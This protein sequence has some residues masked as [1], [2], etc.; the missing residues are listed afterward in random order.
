M[1]VF[2]W[3]LS[4]LDLVLLGVA[5]RYLYKGYQNGLPKELFACA[6]AGGVL[7]VCLTY[8]LNVAHWLVQHTLL[9]P[10]VAEIS[11]YVG[12]GLA[13]YLAI[14]LAG[15]IL[16]QLA[17][18]Q[19]ANGFAK[20]ATFFVSL[21]HFGFSA[22]FALFLVLLI[23]SSFSHSVICEKS[24]VSSKVVQLALK[25]HARVVHK[26]HLS[27]TSPAAPQDFHITIYSSSV[28]E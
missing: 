13:A 17:T 22:A 24:W 20:A 15:K 26:I 21:F 11:A 4:W 9:N 23:P 18:I 28:G 6:R 14:G 1:N 7:F 16:S 10:V 3:Q 12:L 2:G 25:N 19:F 8:F 5:C 27:S